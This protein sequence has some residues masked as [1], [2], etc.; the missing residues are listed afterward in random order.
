MVQKASTG[1]G[2]GTVI[3]SQMLNALEKEIRAIFRPSLVKLNKIDSRSTLIG[4]KKA[5]E[6]NIVF[7]FEDQRYQMKSFVIEGS[8]GFI[9]SYMAR[10]ED[11]NATA[12][13]AIQ[14]IR[15]FRQD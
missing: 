4:N 15:T 10:A 8:A 5:G 7:S 6:V 9:L 1:M 13:Q 12:N 11:F 14:A 2:P 3:D